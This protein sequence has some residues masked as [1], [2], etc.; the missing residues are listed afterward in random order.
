[1]GY[2]NPSLSIITPTYN[3]GSLLNNCFIVF[4]FFFS[5][6]L[7]LL[8]PFSQEQYPKVYVGMYWD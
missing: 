8:L 4:G 3:R 2:K 7:R 1:M 5:G 6:E